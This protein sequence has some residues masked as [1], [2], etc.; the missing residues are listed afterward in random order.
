VSLE[1]GHIANYICRYSIINRIQRFFK[2]AYNIINIKDGKARVDIKIVGG[3]RMRL[4][5]IIEKYRSYLET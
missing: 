1:P 2:N 3:K 5:Q 4:L